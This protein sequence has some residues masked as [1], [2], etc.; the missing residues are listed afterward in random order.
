L[1]AGEVTWDFLHV[2]YTLDVSLLNHCFQDYKQQE[3]YHTNSSCKHVFG[4]GCRLPADAKKVLHPIISCAITANLA[5]IALGFATHTGFKSTLGGSCYLL[6]Y[7]GCL[8][9]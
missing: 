2:P 9:N 7:I 5:A 8:Q 4:I 1:A 6:Y 3:Q